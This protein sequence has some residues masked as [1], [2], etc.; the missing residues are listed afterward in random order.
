MTAYAIPD[1]PPFDRNDDAGCMAMLALEAALATQGDSWPAWWLAGMSGDAFKFVYDPGTV[2]EPLRDRVPVDVLT[3][4]SRAAGWAGHWCLDVPTRDVPALVRESV[5]R[6]CPV[7]TPFLGER[8]YHGMVLIVGIDPSKRQFLLRIARKNDGAGSNYETIAIPERWDGPVPGAV[9]WAGTPLFI[10]DGRISP[11]NECQLFDQ[12][13]ARAAGLHTGAP[14]PYA[15][16]PGAQR[17]SGPPLAGRSAHQGESALRALREDLADGE[18]IDFG[19]IWRIDAQLGQLHYDRTNAGRFL[20]AAAGQHHAG[21]LLWEAAQ[22]YEATARIAA[23]LQ[24]AFWDQRL[25]QSSDLPGVSAGIG[26]TSSLVYAVG[27]LPPVPLASLG[28]KVPLL[29]IPWGSAA[30]VDSPPRRRA[31][32]D[33]VDRIIDHEECSVALLTKSLPP[34]A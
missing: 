21:R 24:A 9:A 22:H 6:G 5:Q 1:V 3:L 10:L 34:P 26:D 11:P 17:Y 19:R 14:L 31:V 27:H 29:E 4:A 25:E 32:L 20:R 16:H 15:D 23:Q 7:I 28:H 33:M 8:W 12:A 2:F 13:F 30:V 18:F